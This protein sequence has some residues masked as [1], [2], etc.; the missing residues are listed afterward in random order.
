VDVK[1]VNPVHLV[2]LRVTPALVVT[3]AFSTF[4]TDTPTGAETAVAAE[5]VNVSVPSPPSMASAVLQEL[6]TAAT[7]ESSPELPVNVLGAVVRL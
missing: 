1:E 4:V 7:K 3:E 5:I 6:A 2:V